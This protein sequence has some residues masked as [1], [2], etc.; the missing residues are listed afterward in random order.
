MQKDMSTSAF[1]TAGKFLNMAKP[2]RSGWTHGSRTR[3]GAKVGQS[4][5]SNQTSRRAP[6]KLPVMV[7]P[8]Q[9]TFRFNRPRTT[10]FM[11]TEIEQ[12]A[13]A[14]RINFAYSELEGIEDLLSYH[15]RHGTPSIQ[16]LTQLDP[17]AARM[18][19]EKLAEWI[20]GKDVVEIGAGVGF[21]ALELS[22]YAKSVV[23][24]ES[25]PAWSWVFT[26]S[27]YRHKPKNLTWIFGSAETM[28]GKI[29]GDICLILTRSGPDEMREIGK[30]FAPVVFLPFQDAA[31]YFTE[32][33]TPGE[34]SV[35]SGVVKSVGIENLRQMLSR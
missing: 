11:I 33:R 8:N 35:W 12:E 13:I 10:D 2:T 16:I 14:D 27:L 32:V 21:L 22:R 20:Q 7:R 6:P 4:N 30:A 19:G 17:H 34:N 28:A 31:N 25:D 23:A 3:P 15:S 29:R 24:I 18:T 1:P 26:R 9:M 5:R